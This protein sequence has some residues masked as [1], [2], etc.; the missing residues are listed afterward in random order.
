MKPTRNQL[1]SLLPPLMERIM[2]VQS[3][4]IRAY[5]F[6]RYDQVCAQLHDKF[7]K[8]YPMNKTETK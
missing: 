3:G 2:T 7:R 5:Y 6:K 4:R 8:D 1:R